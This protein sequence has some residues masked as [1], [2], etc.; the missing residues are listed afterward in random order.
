MRIIFI[1]FLILSPL[2]KAFAGK[3]E[4]ILL[5]HYQI[6]TSENE[7]FMTSQ[8]PGAQM[9]VLTS[10]NGKVLFVAKDYIPQSINSV[11][12]RAFEAGVKI[13]DIK[14]KKYK[15]KSLFY[16]ETVDNYYIYSTVGGHLLISKSNSIFDFAKLNLKEKRSRKVANL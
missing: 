15:N 4:F 10:K 12:K 6:T 5:N 16:F 9:G 13:T 7:N 8:L 1:I 11:K 2:I 3:K 14:I